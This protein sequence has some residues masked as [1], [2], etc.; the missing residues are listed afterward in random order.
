M[1]VCSCD[2][3]CL[4]KHVK[5]FNILSKSDCVILNEYHCFVLPLQPIEDI[6]RAKNKVLSKLV[7]VI[8]CK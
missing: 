5:L 2:L 6:F 4:G 7:I 3:I 1:I 8:Q